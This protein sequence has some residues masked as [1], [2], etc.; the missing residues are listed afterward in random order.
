MVEPGIKARQAEIDRQIAGL[1]AGG[2]PEYEDETKDNYTGYKTSEGSFVPFNT[3]KPDPMVTDNYGALNIGPP[4]DDNPPA[5]VV[6]R[7]QQLRQA[8]QNVFNRYYRGG[9][10]SVL[11]YWLRRYASG[12]VVDMDLKR[13]TKDGVE[14]YQDENNTLIPV[15]ELP[16]LKMVEN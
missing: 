5:E 10:G 1:Q 2:E 7:D 9:S 8:A 4:P 11:P 16:N 12:Q 6:Y 13:V 3:D 15:S 14:Y